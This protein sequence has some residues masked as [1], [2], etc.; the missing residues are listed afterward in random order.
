MGNQTSG[1][2]ITYQSAV[3][4]PNYDYNP[5]YNQERLHADYTGFYAGILICLFVA[6]FLLIVNLALGCCSPYKKY[7]S[8]WANSG[9]RMIL[10]LF[11]TSPKDQEPILI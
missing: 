4:G 6:V 5:N 9:N 10:P 2:F 8:N 3:E 11:I 1:Y 7:W